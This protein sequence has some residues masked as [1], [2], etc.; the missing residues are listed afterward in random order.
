MILILQGGGYLNVITVLSTNLALT[1][2]F[3]KTKNSPTSLISTFLNSSKF[4]YS[5]L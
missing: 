2:P 4:P 3:F 1:V 5:T